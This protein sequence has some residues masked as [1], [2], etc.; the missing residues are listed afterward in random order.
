MGKRERMGDQ[1]TIIIITKN[2][3]YV[4]VFRCGVHGIDRSYKS[5]KF[6]ERLEAEL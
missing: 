6:R 1:V 5:C 3:M 2:S 4:C